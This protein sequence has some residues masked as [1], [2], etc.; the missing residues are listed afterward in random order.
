[1]NFRIASVLLLSTTVATSTATKS[2]K[3]VDNSRYRIFSKAGGKIFVSSANSPKTKSSK[4]MDLDLSASSSLSSSLSVSIIPSSKADKSKG[5]KC[6]LSLSTAEIL[7]H[8]DEIDDA[9]L[10]HS[11]K[12]SKGTKSSG[13]AA[14]STAGAE[15]DN[16]AKAG[17]LS[18]AKMT[19]CIPQ[20]SVDST[21]QV[22]VYPLCS[23]IAL[24][25]RLI[26]S[27][28]V[29]LLFLYLLEQPTYTPTNEPT[30]LPTK[31]PSKVSSMSSPQRYG[32]CLK[33]EY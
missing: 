24:P 31:S 8:F 12:S 23:E 2:D 10:L 16:S 25:K 13:K 17:K 4:I 28:T 9:H 11:S 1:M 22:S 29:I 19:K 15:G 3:V 6:S 33:Q 32:H 21:D 5:A 26:A 7:A 14:K 20:F 27:L 18:K 30:D